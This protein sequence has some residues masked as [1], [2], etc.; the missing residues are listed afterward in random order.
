[1]TNTTRV[2]TLVLAPAIR[3]ALAV[4][5]FLGSA[6]TQRSNEYELVI[7]N[8]RVMDPE[9]GLD[10]VRNVAITKGTIRAISTEPMRGGQVIDA[11]GL[12]VAPGFIDL[13][14]HGQDTENYATKP[15][16]A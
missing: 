4:L 3:V 14:Q 16:T 11:A 6:C 1:M 13:H 15:L 12:T 7:I 10:A 2:S 8:G 9:S 5:L